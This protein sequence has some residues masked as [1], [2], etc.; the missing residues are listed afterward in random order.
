MKA[1]GWILAAVLLC[2]ATA[3]VLD[4]QIVRAA[5][6]DAHTQIFELQ[7]HLAKEKATASRLTAEN[8]TLRSNQADNT[9]LALEATGVATE[10][11]AQLTPR[12]RDR[13]RRKH[14]AALKA[15]P[16]GSVFFGPRAEALCVQLHVGGGSGSIDPQ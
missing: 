13:M 10:C 8:L 6:D 5:R 9:L 4:G 15:C 2:V 14:Q 16:G 3:A 11:T 12:Q 1:A 7:Q